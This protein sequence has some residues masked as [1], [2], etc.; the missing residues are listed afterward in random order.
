MMG[1]K[2][3]GLDVSR[4]SVT[5]C[6]LS[7]LPADL[8]RFQQVHKCPS[9]PATREGIAALLALDFDAAVMEPTG[10]HYAR[11]WVHHL[12]QAGKPIRWVGHREI[13]HYR[14]SNK[15]PNKNDN[16][17][18]IAIAA[19]AVERWDRPGAFV[20]GEGNPIRYRYLELQSLTRIRTPILNRLRQQLSHE[21]P[22]IAEKAIMRPWLK[23]SPGILYA[24]T[25]EKV[26]KK[27]R[28]EF[29]DSIGEGIGSFTQGLAK[30]LLLIDQQELLIEQA[31][32]SELEKECYQRYLVA[33]D[34]FGIN[35]KAAA[36]IIAQAFPI[37][38]FLNE[39]GRPIVERVAGSK[40]H[41]SLS[42]FK[43]SLGIGRVQYQSGGELRWKAG[44]SSDCRTALFLWVQGTVII[45]KDVS[46]PAIAKL[47]KYYE[48]GS[49][50]IEDGEERHFEPGRGKQRIMR[51]V[52]RLVED[53]FY[54]LVDA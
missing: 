44:G 16:A 11:I 36:A 33:F 1:I 41:R 13:R 7:E 28:K 48:E 19:Y 52:R 50:Q 4:G 15:L 31:I 30:Q 54:E 45:R 49:T 51:V 37:E 3:L 17:D 42:S 35:G 14:E 6:I 2:I 22:E 23:Q 12:E 53:L 9:F 43:L 20:D 47:R 40:R 32:A 27:W 46:K 34:K 29:E 18:A 8:K 39:R 5:A 21:C 38:R 25:G 26:S 24:L 10:I